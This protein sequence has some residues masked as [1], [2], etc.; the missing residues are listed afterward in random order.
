MTSISP[1]KSAGERLYQEYC[2]SCHQPDGS[3]VPGMYPPVKES[4]WVNGDKQQLIKV[5]LLGWKRR[6]WS[7][8]NPTS[9]PC[10]TIGL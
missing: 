6:S 4:D 2:S 9:T 1:P 3:G 8:A 10:R 7:M 5:M